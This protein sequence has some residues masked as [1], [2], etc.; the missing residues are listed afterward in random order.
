[1]NFVRA[2]AEAGASCRIA[3]TPATLAHA[4]KAIPAHTRARHVP[5]DA[6]RGTDVDLDLLGNDANFMLPRSP[7]QALADSSRVWESP[8]SLR[9]QS[10]KR[11]LR[12]VERESLPGLGSLPSC[13]R[14]MGIVAIPSRAHGNT[15]VRSCLFLPVKELTFALPASSRFRAD[16]SSRWLAPS[17]RTLVCGLSDAGIVLHHRSVKREFALLRRL[18]GDL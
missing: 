13:P 10:R 4:I 6:S 9:R 11:R 18:R 2:G 16:I 17:R 7:S 5:R 1:V 15:R 3:A 8:A 12:C 14:S